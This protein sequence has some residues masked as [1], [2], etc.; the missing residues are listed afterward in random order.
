MRNVVPDMLEQVD[1]HRLRR[2]LFYLSKDPLPYRKLNVTVPGHDQNT[3]YQADAWITAQLRDYGY[4][5]ERED[6]P[7]QAFGFDENRPRQH[8]YALPPPDAPVY[9]AYNLY[10]KK[11]GRRF[12]EEII[13]LLAHKDS[14]SWIDSPGAY[15]NG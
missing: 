14:Q 8:A 1:A 12:P 9:T 7:V 11:V 6:C 10:A 15:D 4:S 5:V 2:N 3:L 13:L